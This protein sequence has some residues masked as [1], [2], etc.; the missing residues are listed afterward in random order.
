MKLRD[1]IFDSAAEASAFRS[2]RT[3][4][5][6]KLA[7]YPQ[8]PLAKII[9]VEE[10]EVTHPELYFY[11]T[12]SVDYTFCL[13]SGRPLLSIDFDGIGGG[14]SREGVYYPKRET[15]DPNRELKML[16]KL[17][18]TRA[19]GYPLVVVSCEEMEPLEPDDSYMIV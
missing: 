17:E 16:S 12:T 11:R 5:S 9:E 2:L 3:R 10:Q 8:L 1:S 6:S 13:S 14:Y 19:V 18:W 7:L 4:W 15:P